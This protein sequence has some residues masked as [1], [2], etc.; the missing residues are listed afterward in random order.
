MTLKKINLKTDRP[1][2]KRHLSLSTVNYVVQKLKLFE[3]VNFENR[4]L[5]L[6]FPTGPQITWT[7]T[8]RI[9]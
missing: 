1:N 9:L 4:K 6:F 5:N 3:F 8:I 2:Q 7:C